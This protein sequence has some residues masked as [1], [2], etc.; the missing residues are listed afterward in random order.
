MKSRQDSK[1]KIRPFHMWSHIQLGLGRLKS[2]NPCYLEHPYSLLAGLHHLPLHFACTD[3]FGIEKSILRFPPIWSHF[4]YHKTASD[5]QGDN[6]KV[7][8]YDQTTK[9]SSH[10]FR[11]PFLQWM[12]WPITHLTFQG[13]S[14]PW[15]A[16]IRWRRACRGEEG[17]VVALGLQFGG[18]PWFPPFPHGSPHLRWDRVIT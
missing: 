2:W 10:Y 12:M 11:P 8:A 5:K 15:E 6:R 13:T 17:E 3:I 1:G 16:V 14:V 4:P 7:S 9:P 18:V